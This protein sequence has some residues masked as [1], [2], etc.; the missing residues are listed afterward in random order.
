MLRPRR[1]QH[2]QRPRVVRLWIHLVSSP[3][4][5]W[6]NASLP[7]L[8]RTARE[9]TARACRRAT[10]LETSS[11]RGCRI[12]IDREAASSASVAAKTRDSFG[13]AA[14]GAE[15]ASMGGS[16]GRAAISKRR[17]RRRAR[18]RGARR[19]RQCFQAAHAAPEH[20]RHAER[21]ARALRDRPAV[22]PLRRVDPE[23]AL[24]EPHLDD[25]M[26]EGPAVVVE[27]RL[28]CRGDLQDPVRSRRR[29]P[30]ARGSALPIA[31][32]RNA[33]ARR[34]GDRGSASALLPLSAARGR[35]SRRAVNAGNLEGTFVAE[36]HC[37]SSRRASS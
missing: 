18:V 34:F 37:A 25:H 32:L 14:A 21:Q 13:L 15:V 36:A 2:R 29:T 12:A 35:R 31:A 20:E 7:A 11:V 22:K 1:L 19:Q 9:H 26:V 28:R 8:L 16:A 6:K 33:T 10:F 24:P 3:R 17:L 5:H 30:A 23:R 4:P 27:R